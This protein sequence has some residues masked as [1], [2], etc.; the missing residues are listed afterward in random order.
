MVGAVIA[1]FIT[2]LATALWVTV[3]T[4]VSK[5][6]L[7]SLEQRLRGQPGWYRQFIY[8][9]NQHSNFT[10]TDLPQ[11]LD[12]YLS[13]LPSIIA[14]RAE[15]RRLSLAGLSAMETALLIGTDKNYDFSTVKKEDLVHNLVVVLLSHGAALNRKGKD[16]AIMNHVT[17][18]LHLAVSK[19]R[20]AVLVSFMLR[21]GA[22]HTILDASGYTARDMAASWYWAFFF[23]TLARNMRNAFDAHERWLRIG[24]RV[25]VTEFIQIGDVVKC[26]Y[27]HTIDHFNG[28][29][30]VVG[31]KNKFTFSPLQVDGEADELELIRVLD[32]GSISDEELLGESYFKRILDCKPL[33]SKDSS[34]YQIKREK[35]RLNFDPFLAHGLNHVD[36]SVDISG[37]L[38]TIVDLSNGDPVLVTLHQYPKP[39]FGR[40]LSV[41]QTKHAQTVLSNRMFTVVID[42]KHAVTEQP[43]FELVENISASLVVPVYDDYKN[44]RSL[45]VNNTRPHSTTVNDGNLAPSTL[46]SVDDAIWLCN[47]FVLWSLASYI[48]INYM[49]VRRHRTE[50]DIRWRRAFGHWG[51]VCKNILCRRDCQNIQMGVGYKCYLHFLKCCCP[52]F[53]VKVNIHFVLFPANIL[54]RIWRYWLSILEHIVSVLDSTVILTVELI[55]GSGKSLAAVMHDELAIQCAA[56]TSFFSLTDGPFIFSS[57]VRVAGA[58]FHE[59]PTLLALSLVGTLWHLKLI[60]VIDILGAVHSLLIVF[61]GCLL[62]FRILSP[63]TCSSEIDALSRPRMHA[64]LSLGLLM[65]VF[66]QAIARKHG[67][68]LMSIRNWF[69]EIPHQDQSTGCMKRLSILMYNAAICILFCG[70]PRSGS[71]IP[72]LARSVSAGWMTVAFLTVLASR[73]P[74]LLFDVLGLSVVRLTKELAEY[75]FAEDVV[76][77]TE[78]ELSKLASMHLWYAGFIVT[79]GVTLMVWITQALASIEVDKAELK[80]S[81]LLAESNELQAEKDS[82]RSLR[83]ASTQRRHNEREKHMEILRR[84]KGLECAHCHDHPATA[85]NL[86]CGHCILCQEC[87]SAFRARNGNTCPLPDCTFSQE[88]KATTVNAMPTTLTTC[89]ICYQGWE[90]SCIFRPTGKDMSNQSRIS[91]GGESKNANINATVC[92]HLICV[93]CMVE[94]IRVALKNKATMFEAGGLKCPMHAS[95]CTAMVRLEGVRR[96]LSVSARV[97]PDPRTSPPVPPLTIA[98]ARRFERFLEEASVPAEQRLYC[99]N[100][101]CTD[102]NGFRRLNDMGPL[103]TRPSKPIGFQCV[104]CNTKMCIECKRAHHPYE[105]D[106]SKAATANQTLTEAVILATTKPC[107]HCGFKTSHYHGHS[108]H[109]IAPGTGCPQCHKHWCYSCGKKAPSSHNSGYCP[110]SPR[111]KLNCRNRHINDHLDTSNGWPIDQRCGCPICPDCRPNRPCNHCSGSCVVCKG[112]VPHGTFEESKIYQTLQQQNQQP[113]QHVQVPSNKCTIS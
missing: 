46:D 70:A 68:F 54:C 98:E 7:P 90:S 29:H 75:N 77:S 59:P 37:T 17:T 104:W 27:L 6:G 86:E 45:C 50:L 33:K 87:S 79:T 62:V 101:L 96:L 36:V 43:I 52:R 66:Y 30:V 102:Q 100:Y 99:I 109:H 88:K 69:E 94:N 81:M 38:P 71:Y 92:D 106:C 97:L 2:V 35:V 42:D 73:A 105:R 85:V 23:Q 4:Q 83:Q 12:T 113:Q 95:G 103:S 11:K 19:V 28:I 53:V 8:C 34:S 14:R 48:F 1:T 93:S 3:R 22:N 112:L 72:R 80:R 26:K 47:I 82:W 57:L 65:P 21:L 51:W 64:C 16:G 78:H 5:G 111:C 55:F 24:S 67:Q 89:Y 44:E 40:V 32:P 39:L 56:T 31:V 76:D 108:C 61:L 107:P 41:S 60:F 10:V 91:D 58:V 49:L 63:E 18:P 15:L 9:Q 13:G 84:I 20:D 74:Q 25:P 110:S